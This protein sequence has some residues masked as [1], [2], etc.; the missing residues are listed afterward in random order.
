MRNILRYTR[1]ACFQSVGVTKNKK[2]LRKCHGM[3][4]PR[5]AR[6]VNAVWDPGRDTGMRK[7][8]WWENRRSQ[9]TWSVCQCSFLRFDERAT[10]GQDAN[11]GGGWVWGD[12]NSLEHALS[13]RC[14]PQ[15]ARVGSWVEKSCSYDDG[16]WPWDINTD[17]A[18][19]WY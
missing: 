16:S 4:A 11:I 14:Y 10:V 3:E 17:I 15:G 5:K 6:Q 2:S 12:Q 7:G 8:C 19:L 9:N 1:R 13:M 18:Y